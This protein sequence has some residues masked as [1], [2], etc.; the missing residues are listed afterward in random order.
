MD[1]KEPTICKNCSNLQLKPDPRPSCKYIWYNMYCKAS[2]K[3]AATD[4]LTGEPCYSA[5][6]DLG[7]TYYCDEPFNYCRN[8]NTDCNCEF[9]KKKD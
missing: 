1:K 7:V 8:I 2:P 9:F 6:N 3:E 5:K 4:P